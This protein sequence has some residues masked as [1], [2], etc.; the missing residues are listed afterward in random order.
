MSPPVSLDRKA[1]L[2]LAAAATA[3]LWAAPRTASGRQS[4][5]PMPLRRLGATGE[6]LPV[7]GLGGWHL[8]SVAT[9]KDARQLIEVALDEGIRLLD[10]AESY[11]EGRSERW[12][13]AALRGVRDQVFLM[14]KTHDHPARSREGT[15]R[16]LEGSLERL[17]TDYLD[18]W[19]LHSIKTPADVDRAFAGGAAMEYILEMKAQGVVRHVGVTGH[20]HPAAHLRALEHF[21][22]GMRFDC[23]Q[24]P[25][26]PIDFHQ[27][28]FQREV[29][30]GLIERG[31]GVIAMKTS[32]SG[33]LVADGICTI[34]ECLRFVWGLPVSVAVVGMESVAQL[35]HNAALARQG[36]MA[37]AAMEA[38][39]AR[40]EGRADL[41]LE[42][43]KRA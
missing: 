32:A 9:E 25:L 23:V 24:M 31:I 20:E 2:K 4:P 35:R 12:M 40:I 7:L 17:G 42:W 26:N 37:P 30:P 22:R 8:G 43:Y 38:L 14:T 6:E 41:G 15:K 19:Q 33:R 21:D 1:F 34:D 3:G 39:L 36:A 18:L 16:H 27:T 29:L 13:G 28:S 5:S 11:H 10:N